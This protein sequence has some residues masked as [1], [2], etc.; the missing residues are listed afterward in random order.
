MK[1][2]LF[3]TRVLFGYSPFPVRIARLGIRRYSAGE[4]IQTTTMDV[5]ALPARDF[6]SFV[7]ASPTR[8]D[9]ACTC[10][11]PLYY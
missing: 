7:N 1:L 11:C 10:P 4:N 2:E 5:S 8:M 6:I 3:A 9:D